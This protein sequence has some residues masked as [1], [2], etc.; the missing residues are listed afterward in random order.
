MPWLIAVG[1]TPF[2]QDLF[3]S[4]A[5]RGKL[6]FIAWHTVVIILIWDEGLGANRLLTAA[7]NETALVP[8]VAGILQLPSTRHDSLVTGDTFGREFVAVTVVAEQSVILAGEGLIS[9]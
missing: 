6:V 9:Q 7:A 3:A 8:R 5:A 4:S 1:H 2:G